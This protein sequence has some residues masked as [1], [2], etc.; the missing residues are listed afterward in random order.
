MNF[1]FA[2]FEKTALLE[3]RAALAG[4]SERSELWA[5]GFDCAADF[6]H[7]FPFARSRRGVEAAAEALAALEGEEER[8]GLVAI[9]MASRGFAEHR[10]LEEAM[11]KTERLLETFARRVAS[12]QDLLATSGDEEPLEELLGEMRSRVE[13]VAQTLRAEGAYGGELPASRLVL[14]SLPENSPSAIGS[15]EIDP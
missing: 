6:S 12:A 1:N 15:W 13:S 7:A 11:P 4:A 3:A 5:A 2:T 14:L 8:E 10:E 9:L